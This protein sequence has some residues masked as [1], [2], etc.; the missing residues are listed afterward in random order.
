M[1]YLIQLC[2]GGVLSFF[3]DPQLLYKF[4][5]TLFLI[6]GCI[7]MIYEAPV[8]ESSFFK[9]IVG[10]SMTTDFWEGEPDP[11]ADQT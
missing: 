11:F 6:K 5:R 2:K 9:Q 7:T 1:I 8:A 3:N 10:S 4:L